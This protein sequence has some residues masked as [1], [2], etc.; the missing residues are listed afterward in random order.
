MPQLPP[1][2]C[3]S[4]CGGRKH[5]GR[6]YFYPSAPSEFEYAEIPR[7]YD[8]FEGRH[9][10]TAHF[11]VA[12]NIPSGN[13]NTKHVRENCIQINNKTSQINTSCAH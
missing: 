6:I 4:V 5:L 7:G 2:L 13:S 8:V 3:T 11:G 12:P 9:H 1:S 10:D